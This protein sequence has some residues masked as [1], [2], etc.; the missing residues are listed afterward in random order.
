MTRGPDVV[1]RILDV[2]I[3]G[4]AL[5]VLLPVLALVAL[6]VLCGLGWPVLFSETRAGRNGVPFVLKKFRSMANSRAADGRLLPDARRLGRLGSLLRRYSLDELP[7]L[8]HVLTGDMSIVGPRPLPLRYVARY[9]VEQ[10]RRLE[11]KPG[12][13]GLAQISGRNALS[14]EARLALDTWY[15]EHRG[16]ALDC[17]ILLST[18][19]VVLRAEDINHPGQATMHEFSGLGR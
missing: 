13:T 9:S 2:A 17:R 8:V 3:A 5:L 16:L 11:V 10:A 15:V 19:L 12:I 4:T 7:E 6:A 14:W 1:R 18:V